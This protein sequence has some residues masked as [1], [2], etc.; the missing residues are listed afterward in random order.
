MKQMLK[1]DGGL[2]LRAL[3]AA[4]AMAAAALVLSAAAAFSVFRGTTQLYRPAR[5]ALVDEDRTLVSR[6]AVRLVQG[7]EFMRELMEFDSVKKRAALDGL[8][9]GEYA[10]VIILPENYVNNILYGRDCQGTILLSQSAAASAEVVRSVSEL[11]T[12]LL[13]A[14][15]FGVFAGEDLMADYA[16]EAQLR[17]EFL[18]RSNTLLLQEALD[19]YQDYF[20]LE[21]LP[22]CATGL[23]AADYSAA[24]Y[25]AFFLCLSCVFFTRLYR[26]DLEAGVVPRLRVSGLRWPAFLA[27]KLLFPALFLMVCGL[28]LRFGYGRFGGAAAEVTALLWVLPCCVF[29]AAFA[30]LVLTGLPRSGGPLLVLCAVLGLVCC[31]GILPRD[32][33]PAALVAFGERTPGGC[34]LG[35]LAPSFGGPLRADAA[36]GAAVYCAVA[37]GLSFRRFRQPQQGEAEA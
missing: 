35:L 18:E 1:R 16:V 37:A 30:A 33:L 14:G 31:G 23:S 5:V 6:M 21:T 24:V 15:Q 29:S 10:A 8:E 17:N 9:T 20:V 3:A 26:R 11:G 36:V 28:A 25:L 19:C 2:F 4:L 12:L 27:G 22:Y 7:Q 32:T 13:A 34:A